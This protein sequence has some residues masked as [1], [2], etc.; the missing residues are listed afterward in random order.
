MRIGEGKRRIARI[1]GND[2]EKV[3]EEEA[4]G[5]ERVSTAT[6]KDERASFGT[7]PSSSMLTNLLSVTT[8]TRKC[9]MRDVRSPRSPEDIW[10]VWQEG[11]E[12]GCTIDLI[13]NCLGE[14]SISWN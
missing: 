1:E 9:S 3:V 7:G 13:V 4:E 12:R 5:E 6:A 11:K 14:N 2:E 10:K 8:H